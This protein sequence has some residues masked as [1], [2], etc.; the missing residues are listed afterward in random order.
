MTEKERKKVDKQLEMVKR[1]LEEIESG[2]TLAR[3]ERSAEDQ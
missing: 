2:E 3:C 1:L